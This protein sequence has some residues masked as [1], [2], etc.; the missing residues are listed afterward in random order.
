[1][2]DW[3]QDFILTFTP[4][5]VAINAFGVMPFL[6]LLSEGSSK[7]ERNRMIRVAII[8]AAIVGLVFLFIGRFILSLMGISVG[9]FAIAG[10]VIL[11]LLSINYITKGH[12]LEMGSVPSSGVNCHR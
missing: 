6:I 3:I 8:T 5:F 9:A 2:N 11:L 12:M 4:L 7:H 10:G 1:M